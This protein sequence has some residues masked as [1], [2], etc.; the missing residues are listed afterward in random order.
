MAKNSN[1][2]TA[3]RA[4]AWAAAGTLCGMHESWGDLRVAV[5]QDARKLSVSFGR[6]LSEPFD[7]PQGFTL[8]AS[9]Q[10]IPGDA[11]A[12][13]YAISRYN[14]LIVCRDTESLD[15]VRASLS[16]LDDGDLVL[17]TSVDSAVA[18]ARLSGRH[19]MEYLSC[20]T[21]LNLPAMATGE[22]V[23]TKF[24]HIAMMVHRIPAGFYL[25][26]NDIHTEYLRELLDDFASI[27]R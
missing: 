7:L 17:V 14:Q 24:G 1:N 19:S 18:S 26:W 2:E 12:R 5:D 27:P 16:S 10:C 8:Q 25:Y 4:S 23:R 13:C 15:R 11:P 22:Y 3:P 20:G 9:R 6:P 21:F